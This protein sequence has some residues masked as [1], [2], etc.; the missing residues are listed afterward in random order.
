M[1]DPAVVRATADRSRSPLPRQ[2]SA[3][4][5]RLYRTWDEV[6]D[7]P[8][9]ECFDQPWFLEIFSGTARLT[10][11]MQAQGWFVLPPVDITVAGEV[12]AP[13]NVLEEQ[14]KFKLDAWISSGAIRLVHFGTPCT[15]FSR[16]RRNDGGPPPIGSDKFLFG[17]PGISLLD[18]ENVKLG[19]L[20]LDL[21]LHWCFMI[22]KAAGN[23]TIENPAGSMLR[24]MPQT[25]SFI[26]LFEPCVV[27]LDLCSY[28]SESQKPTKFLA[29]DPKFNVLAASCPGIGPSHVHVKLEG[30]VLH[31]GKWVYR[32]KRAQVYPLALRSKYATV[33]AL[34]SGDLHSS[35]SVDLGVSSLQGKQF[36]RSFSMTTPA[37]DRKR[38]LY[39]ECRFSEHKRV[40]SGTNAI[41][42]GYQMRRG[43][44][45]P[46]FAHEL[47]P[48]AAVKFALS[49][50]HPFN[51]DEALSQELQ[52]NIDWVC[53]SA[54]SVIAW[55]DNKLKF[56]HDRAV[57]LLPRSISELNSINDDAL[58]RLL[59]GCS[60]K[61][62]PQLGSCFHV[63][64]WRELA[65]A[66][67]CQDQGLIDQMLQGLPIVGD[68]LKSGR[69]P[70]MDGN[71]KDSK[72]VQYLLDRAWEVRKKVKGHLLKCK[73]TEF[74]KKIFEATMEDVQEGSC[75]GP[76]DSEEAVSLALGAQDWIPTQRFEVVQKNK[77]RGCD[78]ATVNLVNVV[79]TVTEKLQLPS[80]DLN[81]AALR[82]LVSKAKDRKL[83]AWVLDERKAYRQLGIRPDHRKFSVVGFKHF[84]TG[85]IIYFIMIGHSFGLV[86]AVYN[87]NRRS[88]LLDEILR[89]VFRLVS[90]NFYDDK[91]GFETC[92]T[93]SSAMQV[94][95]MVHSWLGALFDEKKLQ[96]GSEV[97]IL[98]ITYDLVGMRLLIKAGRKE[99]ISDEIDSILEAEALEPGRAGKLK[100]KL[101]FASS[102]LWGKVGR[103]FF[104]ALSE[105]QYIRYYDP[106]LHSGLGPALT[107][108]L[109]Q[110]KKLVQAGPPRKI[111]MLTN[112]PADVVLFTD[113]YTPDARKRE[114]GSSSVGA[115]IFA[116]EAAVPGQFYE[117]VPQRV[118]DQWMPRKTQICL[119]ELVGVIIAFET[120]RDYLQGKTVLLFVDAEAV[121]GALVKGYSA[122]SDVCE[123]VG[124]FWDMALDLGCSVYIDRIST[125]A[126]CADAPSRNKLEIG[127]ALGWKTVLARWPNKVWSEGRAW[128]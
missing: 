105:R 96:L 83:A 21:T 20:F 43:L 106:T 93:I 16:A 49:I 108:A 47:E 112:A 30:K 25:L 66:G 13:A 115:S 98:G 46:I 63:A 100:G 24:I 127:E 122:R 67:K 110:W 92:D 117:V 70:A 55:R 101:G 34:P 81:V 27:V 65:L 116:R 86:S 60:D 57:Q 41:K 97:D 75:L 84:E 54:P 19:T 6:P 32:T 37:K 118:I 74:S 77:V 10:K 28:G 4:I 18:A 23:W 39:T 88:A 50:V 69:W 2:R 73:V 29:S 9:R 59:R 11:A 12:C 62:V 5:H 107:L 79:T 38:A 35:D 17:I 3:T 120:F 104:L 48:G 40:W 99:E 7:V 124:L 103:A 53:G 95:K 113:G 80:T 123:L 126:N 14:L 89:K 111:E 15:T 61:E 52:F 119:I 56:W 114:S 33:M 109:K 1:T 42:S 44:V 125:D 90:F 128:G 68:V 82:C 45:K 72:P 71:R 8:P 87:Y 58:R 78:S 26:K 64:L 102:Q 85:K 94:A 121:E 51:K 31:E 36:S 22:A 91:F 76:F